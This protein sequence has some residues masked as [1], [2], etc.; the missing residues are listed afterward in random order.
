MSRQTRFQTLFGSARRRS[1][2]SG[3]RS[4]A[5]RPRADRTRRLIMERLEERAMLSATTD[6]ELSSLLP[7]N[8]GN[9]SSGFVVNGTTDNGRLGAPLLGY[10]P[11]G[12][13]N[14]DGI[15]DFF[16]AARGSE[17]ESTSSSV[18]RAVSRRSWICTRSTA[19]MGTCSTEP[20]LVQTPGTTAAAWETSITTVFRT[21]PSAHMWR[22]LH[23]TAWTRD[24]LSWSSEA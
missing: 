21:W 22:I 11:L 20:R 18:E 9:G 13:V 1:S 23:P 7:A 24:K 15:D 5:K 19:R 8:G 16:L 4:T 2:S 14:Q 6:F 3:A 17:Q 12:D 10:Q